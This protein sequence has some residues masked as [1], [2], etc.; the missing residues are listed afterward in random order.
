[1]LH[2]RPYHPQTQG[3]EER[4]NRTLKAE[5]LLRKDLR[6]LA[7]A[8]AAFDQWREVYNFQRPHEALGLEVPAKRYRASKR[9]YKACLE[10]IFYGQEDVVLKVQVKGTMSWKGRLYFVG[11]AFAGER[12]ALRRTVEEGSYAVYYSHQRLGSIDLRNQEQKRWRTLS[13]RD[14]NL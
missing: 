14:K 11:E 3:K 8:Q 13:I 9:S 4:L 5:V 6:D 12:V 10:P 2:G 1:V 7:E